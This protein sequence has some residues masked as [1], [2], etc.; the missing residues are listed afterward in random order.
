MGP[1]PASVPPAVQQIPQLLPV[2]I[3][4]LLAKFPS[5]LHMGDVVP[6]P[7]HRVEHHIHTGG[8]PPIFAKAS[9]LDPENPEIAKAEFK[10][11]ESAGIVCLSPYPWESPLHMVSKKDGSWW[12]CG[13]YRCLNLITTPDKYWFPN[14]KALSKALHG[15]TFF[16]KSIW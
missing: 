5:I 14:M 2:D 9:R 13:E 3:R 11:L 10:Q 4:D 8:H 7:S 16:F 1:L 15:C 12:P 6:N